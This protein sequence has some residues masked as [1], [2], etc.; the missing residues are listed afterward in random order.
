MSGDRAA[1]IG[2]AVLTV[3]K[4]LQA[5]VAE[6][7]PPQLP[8]DGDE[9]LTTRAAAELARRSP[10]TIRAWVRSGRLRDIGEG[11]PLYRRK[12]V[13]EAMSARRERA[14]AKDSPEAR[15]RAVL[16]RWWK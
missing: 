2:E 6:R 1:Q 8:A 3:V 12:D 4:L 14:S 16:R 15:A 10:E 9:L 11:R 7:H 13:L 5:E